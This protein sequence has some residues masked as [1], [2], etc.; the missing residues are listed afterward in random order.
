MAIVLLC[1]LV[2]ISSMCVYGLMSK[3]E[4]CCLKRHLVCVKSR[5]K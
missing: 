2:I 5:N 1:F 3:S 4:K